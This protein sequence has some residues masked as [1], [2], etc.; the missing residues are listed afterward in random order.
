MDNT[1]ASL[2]N[3]SAGVNT[4][5]WTRLMALIETGSR[6]PARASNVPTDAK[7]HTCG[8]ACQTQGRSYRIAR[9]ERCC[10]LGGVHGC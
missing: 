6:I 2:T 7:R 1:G 9:T 5:Y 8:G 10:N 4:K 3:V